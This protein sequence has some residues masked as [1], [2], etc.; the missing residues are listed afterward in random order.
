MS[1]TLATTTDEKRDFDR[2][3]KVVA[4]GIGAFVETGRAL[5]EI[6]TRKLYREEYGTFEEY[7]KRS[8]ELTRTYAHRLIDA[9]EIMDDLLPI[10][11]ILPKSESQCREL[12]C[13]PS[14]DLPEV[15]T[16]ICG[17]AEAEDVNVTAKYIRK[18]VEPY[19]N[20]EE[21]EGETE[22]E[23]EEEEEAFDQPNAEFAL[24]EWLRA[25]LNK[26]PK[27][28]REDAAH[29][30]RQ[31][32][33]TEYGLQGGVTAQEVKNLT[34]QHLKDN[35]NLW[36]AEGDLQNAMQAEINR[37]PERYRVTAVEAIRSGVVKVYREMDT[38]TMTSG[39]AYRLRNI[40]DDAIYHKEVAALR[41]VMDDS[42]ARRKAMSTK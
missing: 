28:C 22:E 42:D 11:D 21:D 19:R 23:V 40:R 39:I 9:A 6:R 37:W 8:H 29:W 16:A 24:I 41:Q 32:L 13:V 20:T 30:I 18:Q 14:E 26:W 36:A 33:E 17:Q 2:L 5:L 3:D 12:T 35:T 4:A 25:T 7:A 1:T 15:W 27:E 10:G 31:I 34:A 38:S